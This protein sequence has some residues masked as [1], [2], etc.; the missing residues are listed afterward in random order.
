[1]AVSFILKPLTWL[2]SYLISGV[3]LVI[4]YMPMPMPAPPAGIGGTGSLTV[5]TAAS[6]VR[7]LDAT[8]VAF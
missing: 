1:M 4:A 2:C 3:W 5:A 6:V 8:D 7:K